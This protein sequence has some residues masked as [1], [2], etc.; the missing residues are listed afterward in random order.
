MGEQSGSMTNIIIVIGIFVVVLGV[1]TIAFPDV[2]QSIVDGMKNK[3][4]SL[5]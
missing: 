2:A 4:T 1:F 3:L 5:W